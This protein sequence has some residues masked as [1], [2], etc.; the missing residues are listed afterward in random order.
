MRDFRIALIGLRCFTASLIIYSGEVL[1][2][3]NMPQLTFYGLS[4]FQGGGE[5]GYGVKAQEILGQVRGRLVLPVPFDFPFE[6]LQYLQLMRTLVDTCSSFLSNVVR[7]N[8]PFHYFRICVMVC[9]PL[10]HLV[11]ILGISAHSCTSYMLLAFHYCH[12]I[13]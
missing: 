1:R 10:L 7:I 8:M 3:F 4:I 9:S 6:M 2:D 11:Y 13:V 12:A 5:T